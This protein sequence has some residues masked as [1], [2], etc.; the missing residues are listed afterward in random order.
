MPFTESRPEELAQVRHV[1]PL[2]IGQEDRSVATGVFER[3]DLRG[4]EF[5]RLRDREARRPLALRRFRATRAA[6]PAGA[7]GWNGSGRSGGRWRRLARDAPCRLVGPF[8][9]VHGMPQ[10]P[11]VRPL[12]E[13][14]LDDDLRAH[15]VR[16]AGKN[17]VR[18]KGARLTR[19]GLQ[20]GRE[21]S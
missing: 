20:T 4:D 11:L 15:P 7:A 16:V 12:G 2:P 17:R 3:L 1:E 14:H 6:D 13:L 10:Q 5:E 18:R 8:A 9:E 21:P 19:Q